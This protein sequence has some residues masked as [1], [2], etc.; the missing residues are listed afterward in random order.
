MPRLDAEVLLRHVLGLDRTELFVRLR[1]PLARSASLSCALLEKHQRPLVH[2]ARAGAIKRQPEDTLV[3]A[4]CAR[5]ERHRGAELHVVRRARSQRRCSL[6]PKPP[7]EYPSAWLCCPPCATRVAMSADAGPVHHVD[8][9]VDVPAGFRNASQL[10]K[11]ALPQP[12]SG[13]AVKARRDAP[14]WPEPLGQIAPGRPRLAKP[15]QGIKDQAV[16]LRRP[17]RARRLRQ[18]GLDTSLLVVGQCVAL[19]GPFP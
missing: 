13:P 1:E 9:P 3:S 2:L 16:V 19:H 8:L 14:P 4:V 15:E 7:R 18:K 17:P 10:R 5:K 6:L 11:D 12:R